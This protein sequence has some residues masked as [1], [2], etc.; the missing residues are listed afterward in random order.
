MSNNKGAGV[1]GAEGARWG[2]QGAGRMGGNAGP[3]GQGHL[4]AECGLASGCLE[5]KPLGGSV[6]RRG[7]TGLIG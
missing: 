1:A 6:R 2:R 3:D 5:R 4:D 7:V